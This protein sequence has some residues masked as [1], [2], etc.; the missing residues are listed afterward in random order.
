MLSPCAA[1]VPGACVCPAS[2]AV[3]E[4]EGAGAAAGDPDGRRPDA[5][6]RYARAPRRFALSAVMVA[7]RPLVHLALQ[8]LGRECR[9]RDRRR[10]CRRTTAVA[11]SAPSPASERTRAAIR[12]PDPI[13]LSRTIRHSATTAK[14]PSVM[15]ASFSWVS[16]TRW[17]ASPCA[18]CSS[19]WSPD[20]TA[21]M[22]PTA[23]DDQRPEA[24]R[25]ERRPLGDGRP[26]CRRA[27]PP[28]SSA[29]G[30]SLSAA[31]RRGQS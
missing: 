21:S 5:H 18:M 25:P 20:S 29:A 27:P 23:P 31:C 26:E 7:L 1:G 19:A 24:D 15:S 12:S 3:A 22:P 2:G 11:R 13:R 9:P 6:R 10:A 14:M 16:M 30:R 8:H 17:T 28:A 4:S